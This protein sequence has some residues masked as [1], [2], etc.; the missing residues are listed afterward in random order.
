MPPAVPLVINWTNRDYCETVY[1]GS[2]PE[3]IADRFSRGD[4]EAPAKLLKSWR[5]ES[6]SHRM[7]RKIEKQKNLPKRVAG[8]IAMVMKELRD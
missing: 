8:F 7:P 6:I 1:G 4:P 3:Q 2:E 5:Q